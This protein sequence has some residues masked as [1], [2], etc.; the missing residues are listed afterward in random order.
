MTYVKRKY[1]RKHKFN[2]TYKGKYTQRELT[3]RIKFVRILLICFLAIGIYQ[4]ITISTN[5]IKIDGCVVKAN[6]STAIH[7]NSH[8]DA[9]VLGNDRS[10]SEVKTV[11]EQIRQL[12]DEHNF[13]WP[14][15]LVNLACCEGLLETDTTNDKGNT[16]SYSID[17]GLYGINDFWHSEISDDCAFDLHCSTLWTMKRINEGYQYEWMCDKKIKGNKTYA[18]IHCKK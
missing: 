3:S 4:Y 8:E 5:N 9:I 1:A 11:E 17:R 6:T 10:S 12:A 16:P 15:Y 13:R 14:D 7:V 18:K 2:K